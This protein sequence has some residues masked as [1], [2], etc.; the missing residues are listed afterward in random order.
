M[1]WTSFDSSYEWTIPQRP[2]WH[3]TIRP[4]LSLSQ[5]PRFV[6]MTVLSFDFTIFITIL[7]TL[8]IH[9]HIYYK[10]ISPSVIKPV[11][12]IDRNHIGCIDE[13]KLQDSNKIETQ[14]ADLIWGTIKS[15][16]VILVIIAFYRLGRDRKW[17][18]SL[19][20]NF[21]TSSGFYW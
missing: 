17:I 4:S 3:Q 15:I 21:V 18:H 13:S 8:V 10:F 2:N 14:T 5:P 20:S 11:V 9:Y 6:Y 19:T 12:Y 16:E 7:I 1:L